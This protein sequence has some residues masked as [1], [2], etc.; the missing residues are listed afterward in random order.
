MS[1]ATGETVTGEFGGYKNHR[2]V[3]TTA[4][5]TQRLEFAAGIRKIDVERPVPVTAQTIN[6]P[7][8]DVLF[9]QYEKYNVILLKDG[10]EI[11]KPA[12][13]F[14]QMDVAVPS[15]PVPAPA[16]AEAPVRAPQVPAAS[17]PDPVDVFLGG[18]PQAAKPPAR[19]ERPIAGGSRW[20]T[21]QASSA[22]VISNGEVVDI[23]GALKQGVVNIVHFHLE[24]SLTSVREG[25]YVEAIA[26]K[27]S[28][29]LTV[30]RV[31]IP[32][33]NAPICKELEL[34]SLPQ[35]WFYS[36]SGK[37]T[38]KLTQRFTESDIDAA[39]AEARRGG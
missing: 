5:G 17:G 3:F 19:V 29:R 1:L 26:R 33:W 35:F 21:K 6:G 39:V 10:R 36:A 31:M 9:K 38:R 30:L 7:L 16:P 37:L 18:P 11:R 28:A 23:E 12:T 22:K 20:N 15:E 27:P 32:D 25:N 24:E 14:K 8:N 34:K 13:L 2:F 4:D